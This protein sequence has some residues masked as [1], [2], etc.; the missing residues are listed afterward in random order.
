MITS[1]RLSAGPKKN[2]KELH[3]HIIKLNDD[4]PHAPGGPSAAKLAE[5]AALVGNPAETDI[6]VFHHEPW[7]MVNGQLIA[8][9]LVHIRFPSSILKVS[10]SA[11]E[12]VVWWSEQS[13][14]ITGIHPSSVPHGPAAGG[15]PAAAASAAGG[16]APAPANP[17]DGPPPPYDAIQEADA[18]SGMIWTVRAMP[19]VQAAVHNTFKI[20]FNIG[21]DIDPDMEGTP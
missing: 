14:R 1:L 16:Q 13:F 2:A 20:T 18:S 21:E 7:Q 10:Y 5:A 6:I 17:F 9:P 12:R 3:V 4:S 8:H 11:K 19:I 15:A